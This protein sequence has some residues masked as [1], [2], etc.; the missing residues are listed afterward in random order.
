MTDIAPDFNKLTVAE[1]KKNLA[2]RGLSQDGKK[3]DLISR[4]T[5]NEK[6]KE[7]NIIFKLMMLINNEEVETLVDDLWALI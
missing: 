4:L 1:L 6:E 3:Q 5:E 7:G 2:S